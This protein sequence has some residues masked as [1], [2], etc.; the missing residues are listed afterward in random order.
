[1]VNIPEGNFYM[2]EN[3]VQDDESPRHL[4]WV[5][6]FYVDRYEVTVGEWMEIRSWALSN[7]YEFSL[8]ENYPLLGST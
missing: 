5:S 2:G 7:G 3:G 8:H 4:V 6:S 1:M